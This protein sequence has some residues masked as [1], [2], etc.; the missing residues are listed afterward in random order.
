MA[1]DTYGGV[2]RLGGGALS[3]KDPTKVDRSGAYVARKIA[4]DLVKN[5]L[6]NKCE[7][8]VAYA[9]GV[10][11]PVSVCVDTFGT[12]KFLIPGYLNKYVT[13]NY[14]LTPRG[15]IKSLGLL[16]INYN[17]VSSYGHFMNQ[18][19]PWEN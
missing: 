13:D 19:M 17:Q 12:D 18:G 10:D 6:C 14:D 7:V 8:Q 4:K 5:G 2:G 1:C 9:I 11:K 3:G 16:D 15:I